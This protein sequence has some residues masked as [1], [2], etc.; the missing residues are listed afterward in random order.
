MT[1]FNKPAKTLDEHIALLKARGLCIPDEDRARHYLS[2]ISYYRFSAYTRPFYI[3][4]ETDHRFLPETT[5][6]DILTLYIF[7]RELRLLLLD[8]IERIEV[9]LRAQMT[10]LLAERYG[11]HGYLDVTVFSDDFDHQRLLQTLSRECSGREVEVFINHYRKK[12][13]NAPE[14]PPVWM[15][16]ELLTFSTVSILFAKSERSQTEGKLKTF[17]GGHFLCCVPGFVRFPT[18]ATSA[19]ITCGYGTGDLASAPCCPGK[20]TVRWIGLKSIMP[21]RCVR[22]YTLTRL[23]MRRSVCTCTWWSSIA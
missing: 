21:F 6:D 18:C 3:P 2:N 7:D 15:S 12:Y 16:M 23:S 4:N 17:M 11:P 9:S 5:F 22:T 10:N 20:K 14:H 1:A 13:L 8:A 19:L